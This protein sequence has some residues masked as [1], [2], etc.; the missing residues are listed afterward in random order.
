MHKYDSVWILQH[1]NLWQTKC[2]IT[3]DLGIKRTAC[4]RKWNHL[5]VIGWTI[6]APS[7]AV[8]R[9][10]MHHVIIVV[11]LFLQLFPRKC[12][13]LYVINNNLMSLS[14]ER[15]LCRCLLRHWPT[16]ITCCCFLCS[17]YVFF[18]SCCCLA[19]FKVTAAASSLPPK[20]KEYVKIR[21]AF[22][23]RH[24]TLKLCSLLS[25]SNSKRAEGEDT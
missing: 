16:V 7:N 14:G 25:K 5:T 20:L 8:Q 24:R 2:D 22:V 4:K 13:W 9:E 6:F 11:S 15:R 19:V 1:I 21:P 10:L 23:M 12:T 17:I 18:C 3:G